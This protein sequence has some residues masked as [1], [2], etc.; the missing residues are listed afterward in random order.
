[1]FIY[2]DMN[3]YGHFL[4]PVFTYMA[5]WGAASVLLLVAARV[6]WVRGTD[7]GMRVR[8]GI[9]RGRFTRPVVAVT[10]AA[11]AA[12]AGLRAWINS[13]PTVL[14]PPRN[15]PGELA[16]GADYEKTYKKAYE[17]KV[18]PK[19][20]ASKVDVDIFP[21]DPRVRFAGQFTM[22]NKSAEPIPELYL[23]L[24]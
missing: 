16:L 7:D 24:L 20:I 2:S 4:G 22:K 13:T 8:L 1:S 14:T 23:G 18:Q 12:F 5:Y 17:G 10:F 15:E 6:F 19:V 3:R 11:P 9:A 21:P